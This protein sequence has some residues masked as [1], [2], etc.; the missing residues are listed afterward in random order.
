MAISGLHI[1]MIAGLGFFL[2]RRFWA[3]FPALVIRWPA[4]KAAA[5]AALFCAA[6]YALLAGLSLPT[7]R[8]LIMLAV[9]LLAL[10]WQ[11]SLRPTSALCLALLLVLL[12]DPG[13][14]LAAGFWLSFTAVAT[15]LY[16]LAGRHALRQ[17]L[18]RWLNL[19]VFILLA[20]LPASFI[21][22]QSASLL[23]PIAN[24]IAIP[25]V[26]VTVVP[27]TLSAVAVGMLST[28]LETF[29]L[30]GAALAMEWLWGFLAWLAN[31]EWLQWLQLQHATPPLWTL[32]FVLPGLLLILAP[33]GFPARYLGVFLCLPLFFSNPLQLASGDVYFT[34]LDTGG[35]LIIIVETQYHVLIYDTGPRI[36]RTN[37]A[38]RITLLPFLRERGIH[39]IDTLIVSHADSNHSGGVRTL[40]ENV[41]VDRILTGSIAEVPIENALP[42]STQQSWNWDGADFSILHP[43]TTA[44][45]GN[46][47]SCV[48]R[49]AAHNRNIL[50]SGDIEKEAIKH[51]Q[52]NHADHLDAD[53][54][55]PPHHGTR[56]K[57]DPRFLRAVKPRFILLATAYQ[58]RYGHPYPEALQRYR[59]TGAEVLN[60]AW[61]GAISF[62]IQAQ[63]PLQAQKY[64]Q[65]SQRYWHT[66]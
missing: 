51:L 22:F 16:A 3:F 42:C 21:F 33:R 31:T 32:F 64:R 5:V 9:A 47:S 46:N 57:T 20:L 59:E 25:W 17:P 49:I 28:H 30:T 43:S 15:L 39:H 50:I 6:A 61:N 41:K 45:S 60:T 1:G 52:I 19:Q 12:L 2:M 24:L 55:V 48:L 63:T 18:Q 4:Q 23:A 62:H 26:S 54:L 38:A 11:R 34:L 35:G 8:A 40:L 58:N 37:N 29:L 13:A 7:Q 44:W 27:L 53:I 14:P 56:K 36:G 10:V 66:R 65:N